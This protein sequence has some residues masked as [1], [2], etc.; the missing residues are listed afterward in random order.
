MANPVIEDIQPNTNGLNDGD[1]ACDDDACDDNDEE[2]SIANL[3]DNCPLIHNL[4]EAGGTEIVT[5]G[6][7]SL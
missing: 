5:Q 1:D 6:K 2:D 4:K 7:A 3:E